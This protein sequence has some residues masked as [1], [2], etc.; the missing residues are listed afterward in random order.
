MPNITLSY[1]LR[2]P[3]GT[4]EARG[5]YLEVALEQIGWADRLGFSSVTLLEHHATADGYLPS[6]TVF[7]AAAAVR[8][9]NIGLTVMLIAPF[10][11]PLRAAEDLAIVDLLS[12]GRL[13]V[14][15]AGGYVPSEFA[16]F[17]RQLAERPAAVTEMIEVL[18]QA[19]TGLPFPYRGRTVQV[20][21]RPFRK[22]R[23]YILLGGSSSGSARRAARLADG[24]AARGASYDQYRLAVQ[25][26]GK[27]DPGPQLIQAGPRTLYVSDDPQRDW[28]RIAPYFMSDMNAYARL[29]DDARIDNGYRHVSDS[30]AL[31]ATGQ[32]AIVTPREFLE[33]TQTHTSVTLDPLCGG[34]DPE[35][36][37]ASLRRIELSLTSIPESSS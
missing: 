28:P 18:K 30:D 36:S 17:G 1:D 14:I 7:A 32:Y 24:Y 35:L 9:T 13:R 16:M 4:S 20:T 19:W 3:D 5:R 15:V 11:D 8:T 10:H 21:P 6:P 31:R 22:P 23:P 2:L 26:L 27:P 33:L 34:M 29:A 12:K 25:G 37:W